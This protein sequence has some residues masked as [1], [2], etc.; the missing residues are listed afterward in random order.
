[1]T[2]LI[3]RTLPTAVETEIAIDF[4]RPVYLVQ[5]VVPSGT[6]YLSTG[7]EI[8]FETNDY[9]EGQ[10][11]VNSFSWD[12]DGSQRGSLTLS[13]EG[14]AASALVLGGTLNDLECIIYKTYLIAAGGNTTP[15][16]YM[17]GSLDE[18]NISAARVRVEVVSTNAKTSFLPNRYHTIAEGFNWLPVDGER[19]IWGSEVFVLQAER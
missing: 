19:V 5:L 13:N 1:M 3:K 4:T 16:F 9:I 12:A 11:S 15:Q 10:V 6:R 2:D 18:T 8:T 14:N 17:R 7:P